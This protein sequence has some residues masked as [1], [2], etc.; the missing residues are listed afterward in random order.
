MKKTT[1]R[2]TY[3]IEFSV[4]LLLLIFMISFFLSSQIFDVSWR[5]MIKGETVNAYVGMGLISFSVIVVVLILWEDFLFPVKV[6]PGKDG[7]I[8]RHHRTKL[9]TELLI[10]CLIPA[11]YVFV[12]LNFEIREVRFFIW[13]AICVIVPI[14]KLSSGINNYNDFLRLADGAIEYRNNEK[15]GVFQ[16]TDIQKIKL[17]RD[18]GKVLHKLEIISK[19]NSTIIDLDEMELDAFLGSIDQFMKANYGKVIS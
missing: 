14:V 15:A 7:V 12:Y 11:I 10:Y 4:G 8:F 9:K 3:P 1:I 2:K 16:L 13:A 5:D 19:N 18:E 17:M 6:K